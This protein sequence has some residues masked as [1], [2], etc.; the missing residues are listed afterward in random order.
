VRA[1]FIALLL[2][3]GR[4][5]ALIAPAQ[6]KTVAA[7]AARAETVSPALAAAVMDDQLANV[8]ARFPLDTETVTVASGPFEL[9]DVAVNRQGELGQKYLLPELQH[10][11]TSILLYL[12]EGAYGKMLAGAKVALAAE[13]ARRFRRPT[14][15][16]TSRFEGCQ[17]LILADN[18]E[19]VAKLDRVIELVRKDARQNRWL[20]GQ[21]IF[22][23]TEKW[24]EDVWNVHIV[25]H[26]PREILL[27]TDED[28]LKDV[29]ARLEVL[30][31]GA[32]RPVD[33]LAGFARWNHVV[34]TAPFW[35]VRRYDVSAASEDPSSPI[36]LHSS[37]PIKDHNAI[38]LAIS[39]LPKPARI[40]VCYLTGAKDA[41]AQASELWRAWRFDR[42]ELDSTIQEIKP[43][44]V[45]LEADGGGMSPREWVLCILWLM[46]HQVFV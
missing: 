23:L 21:E 37:S 34:T 36:G 24:E 11:P 6:E 44:V 31:K 5:T 41:K 45:R 14:G 27:G 20:M 18:K 29:L 25:R 3:H 13:G 9:I 2:F 12:R 38:G 28:Y 17:V 4:I 1:F 30:N 15:L 40:H 19:S 42:K 43:G 26:S 32:K 33:S 46:G 35:A 39:Y 16:G 22:S 8:L 10:L 7:D